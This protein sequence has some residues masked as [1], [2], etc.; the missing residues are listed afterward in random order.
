MYAIAKSVGLPATFVELRHQATHEQLPSLTKLR[1]AARKALAWVWEYYWQHLSEPEKLA[2]AAFRGARWRIA[3]DGKLVA[4]LTTYMDED[5]A[6][7]REQFARSIRKMADV[8]VLQ[9]LDQIMDSTGDTKLL[10]RLLE[11]YKAVLRT[12]P[13]HTDATEAQRAEGEQAKDIECVK[14]ELSEGY[15][16]LKRLENALSRNGTGNSDG[17]DL[18][19]PGWSRFRGKWIPKPIGMV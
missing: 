18:G 19:G 8:D 11:L 3:L 2:A 14:A 15:E 16:S 10:L 9:A 17:G 1:S 5:D 12:G 7:R 13:L 6:A 4:V